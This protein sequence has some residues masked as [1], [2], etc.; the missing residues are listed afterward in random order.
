MRAKSN[1]TPI[2]ALTLAGAAAGFVLRC[3]Q[4]GRFFSQGVRHTPASVWA[5]GVLSAV[6]VAALALLSSTLKKRSDYRSAFSSEAPVLA[7]SAAAAALVLAGSLM[8]LLA[9]PYGIQLILGFFGIAAA[10]C[11]AATAILR[12]R[13]TV[14][15]AGL[16]MVPCIYLVVK[17]ILDFKHWSVDP[18]VLDYCFALFAAIAAMC[19][20][21]HLGGFCYGKGRRRLSIFWCLTAVF[22]SAVSLADGGAAH[23]LLTGGLG[24]WA[25]INGWQLLED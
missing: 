11:F 4:L 8:A 14:P 23:S 16:H 5:L 20:V 13:G 6:V 2:A 21:F 9:Q 22:F 25:G 15:S 10:L 12:Y 19:A 3:W 7:V 17:L 24:L 1:R 18:A